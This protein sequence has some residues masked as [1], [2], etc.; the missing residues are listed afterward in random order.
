MSAESG[1]GLRAVPDASDAP[2]DLD[3]ARRETTGRRGRG[4]PWLAL[5]LAIALVTVLLGYATERDRAL[6]LET[7]VEALDTELAA[8]RESL[9]VQRRRMDIVRSHVSELADRISLL[10]QA[11]SEPTGSGAPGQ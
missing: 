4:R 5:L 7:R 3:E 1:P 10:Q 6:E 9:E 8:T 2:G 11:V